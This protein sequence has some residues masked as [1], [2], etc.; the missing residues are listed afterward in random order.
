MLVGPS[1]IGINLW[2]Y[3]MSLYYFGLFYLCINHC[4]QV[5]LPLSKTTG[6]G[7]ELSCL[8]WLSLKAGELK[9]GPGQ[10]QR[11]ITSDL[12]LKSGLNDR[13]ANIWFLESNR[14]TWCFQFL[15][16]FGQINLHHDS[17]FRSKNLIF[18]NT[19]IHR[20]KYLQLWSINH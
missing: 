16:I 3:L 13:L 1:V 9:A 18:V 17:L 4:L 10:N 15:N 2:K 6:E 8:K 20:L 11:Q 5:P 12:G 14:G 19:S 7:G